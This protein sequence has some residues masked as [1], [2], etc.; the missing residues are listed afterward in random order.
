M[1]SERNTEENADQP[2]RNVGA[3]YN[4]NAGLP[5]E[6]KELTILVPAH[7]PVITPPAARALL[8]LLM[9]AA[10]EQTTASIAR[11]LHQ[12]SDTGRRAA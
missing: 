5:G 3:R 12:D 11:N 6:S 2:I 8:R 7:P 9:N 1:N 4:C 10:R